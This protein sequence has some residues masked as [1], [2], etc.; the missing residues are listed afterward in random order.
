MEVYGEEYDVTDILYVT[1]NTGK[2]CL[3]DTSKTQVDIIIQYE[4]SKKRSSNLLIDKP[5]YRR[6]VTKISSPIWKPCIYSQ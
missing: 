3:I 4:S 5:F 2:A 1:N 6:K